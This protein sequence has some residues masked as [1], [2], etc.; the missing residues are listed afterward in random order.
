MV[1]FRDRRSF[2]GFTE[3]RADL[4]TNAEHV[5]VIAAT[6]RPDS[7]DPALRRAGRFDREIEMG[8]PGIEAREEYVF[9]HC[10]PLT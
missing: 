1:S 5:S 10:D 2:C 3:Y 8:V 6:N 7:L 9:R 4:A